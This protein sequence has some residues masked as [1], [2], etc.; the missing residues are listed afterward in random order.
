M[1]KRKSEYLYGY[2]PSHYKLG[3]ATVGNLTKAFSRLRSYGKEN[4]PME[5]GLVFAANHFSFLD[6]P[7]FGAD[8]PRRIYFLAKTEVAGAPVLASV[9]RYFGTIPVRRGESDREAVR[10]MREIARAGEML[11]I[12]IEGTRQRA[13]VPGVPLPGA[14]MVALQEDVPVLP[15]AIVGSESW[16]LWNLHPVTL[17]WGE[18]M[19]FSGLKA[20]SRG[21][22]EATEE[23]ARE[24]RRL[25][26]WLREVHAQGR[27]RGLAVPPRDR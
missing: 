26:E 12:F 6:P 19:R 7:A 16:R 20:N 24:V 4:I 3:Q 13:G 14:A 17:A 21:Y 11:G 25:W 1:S 10:K 18:P 15:A 9:L 5:G 22:R 27:P 8:C 2:A 23:I